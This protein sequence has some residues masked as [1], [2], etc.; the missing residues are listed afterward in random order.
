MG[1]G[2]YGACEGERMSV[3][4]VCVILAGLGSA[5]VVAYLTGVGVCGAFAL[6]AGCMAVVLFVDGL[7]GS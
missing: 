2:A 6:G 1:G 7:V 3:R 5:V 4:Y